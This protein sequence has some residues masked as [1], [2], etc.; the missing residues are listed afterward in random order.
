MVEVNQ[1]LVTQDAQYLAT[2]LNDLHSVWK[3]HDGQIAVGRALFYDKKRRVM[4]RCGRKFGKTELAIYVL[5]RWAMTT[6]NG[7]F[8]YIAPFYNQASEIIWKPN[9]LQNFLG[10][11]SHKYI[12]SVSETDRRITFKNGSFIKLVGSDNYESGRGFNPDG[13]VYDEFKDFDYRFHQGFADNL[14]AKK[15]P[16]LIV[17]TPPEL[18]DHFF[19]RT[20]EEFKLDPRGAYFKRPTH[21]NPYID[22]EELELE[23]QAAINKGEWAKYMREIEA[24]IVPGGANAIFPMLEI[25]RYDERGGFLGESRH[26]KQHSS[27]IEEISKHPKDWRYYVAYD[28]GS[29][30]CFAAIFACV[31]NF[32]K[33]VIVLDEIY[34]KKKMEM[35]SK[36]IYPR[37][38][39]KMKEL[40]PHYSWYQT[41][42]NAAAWF[43]NEVNSEYGIGLIPCEKDINK[44]EEKLSVI[45]DFMLEDLIVFSTRCNG[46]ISEASTYATDDDGK[47]PKKN[48][49]AID[50]LRYLYNAAHLST[51]PKDRHKRADDKRTWTDIDYLEDNEITNQPIDFD[52][53]INNEF[54]GDEELW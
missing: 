53:E 15:A 34:E 31:N 30:S 13:A 27:L 44:K 51:V 17:G 52:E 14:L 47:I 36:K 32:S 25:P 39:L 28:P 37:S 46:L 10:D 2:V 7:Q 23:K 33:K 54:Y 8:Y 29:S 3:P 40:A 5:Y 26:V 6:P 9:R 22:K 18:F 1:K 43:A 24:E 48:D 50:C 41:Y 21:T 20:E 19:V 4:M 12:Q 42:D 16:L 11:N 45:K 38:V 35:S 49:H